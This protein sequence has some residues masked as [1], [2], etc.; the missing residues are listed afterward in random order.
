MNSTE[1]RWINAPTK[2]M[3]KQKTSERASSFSVIPAVNPPA[4][5]QVYR[6]DTMAVVPG[7]AEIYEI[8]V[9]RVRMADTHTEPTAIMA[10]A[11]RDRILPRKARI[12]KLMRGNP[13]MSPI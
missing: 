4:F 5:I 10:T 1:Y 12:R 6:L 11:R 2:V 3:T 7:F 13:G 8:P 9:T